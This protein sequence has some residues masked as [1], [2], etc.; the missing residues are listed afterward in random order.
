M[1]IAE[2][3]SSTLLLLLIIKKSINNNCCAALKILSYTLSNFFQLL[4]C[5]GLLPFLCASHEFILLSCVRALIYHHWKTTRCLRDAEE[6]K[7][8]TQL[9]RTCAYFKMQLSHR[10]QFIRMFFPWQCVCKSRQPCDE[11]MQIVK[12]FFSVN[13]TQ[14]K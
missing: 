9:I 3:R 11:C 2:R 4:H 10:K 7:K 14:L 1:C 13:I 6:E 8:L 12:Q 5:R